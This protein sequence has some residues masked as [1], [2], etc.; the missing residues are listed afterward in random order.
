VNLRRV[1]LVAVPLATTL[2]GISDHDLWEP[3]EPRAAELGREFLDGGSWCVPTLNGAPF[4]EKPPLVYWTIAP[5]IKVFGVHDWAARIPGVLFTWGTL[6]FTWLL[7]GRL[8]GR[9]MLRF[10]CW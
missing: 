9:G 4:M 1:A 2:I 8:Y 6:L 7:A 5:S 3:D 10:S